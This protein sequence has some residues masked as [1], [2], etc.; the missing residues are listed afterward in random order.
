MTNNDYLDWEELDSKDQER[1][2]DLLGEL[3]EIFRKYSLRR[4]DKSCDDS[5][6]IE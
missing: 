4:E 1:V 6:L 3:D 5:T 2:N